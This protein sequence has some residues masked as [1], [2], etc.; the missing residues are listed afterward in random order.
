MFRCE[1]CA[2]EHYVAHEGGR[3]AEPEKCSGCAA[4]WACTLI[5]N[6]STFTNKQMVK[7]QVC[8]MHT[9]ACVRVCMFVVYV[10]GHA[11]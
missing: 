9:N 2:T 8:V 7:M 3:V 11:R 1:R 4:K 6:M 10:I 5:H